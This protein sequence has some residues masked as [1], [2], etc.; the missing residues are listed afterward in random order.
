M[1]FSAT[2]A[3]ASLISNR[4]MSSSV[5]P[6]L[7]STLRAAGTGAF[8]IS[9]GLSPMLAMATTRAARLQAVRLRRSPARPAAPRPAPSTT[10]DELPAWWMCLISRSGVLLRGS[11]SR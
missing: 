11:G 4:S 9:V 6:A 10:P 2:T 5:S 8:S 3:N 1:N 7:A